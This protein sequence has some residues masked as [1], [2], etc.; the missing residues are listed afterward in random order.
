M[1]TFEELFELHDIIERGPNWN[2]IEHIIV[3]LNIP[4]VPTR[5][6]II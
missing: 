4:S 6:I 2:T 1:V 3:T 5:K